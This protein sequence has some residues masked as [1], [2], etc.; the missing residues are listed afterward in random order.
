LWPFFSGETFSK[1]SQF[2]SLESFEISPGTSAVLKAGLLQTQTN[3]AVRTLR[4]HDN[5]DAVPIDSETIQLLVKRFPNVETLFL[6][7]NRSSDGAVKEI[8]G[9]LK[10]KKIALERIG[11][12]TAAALSRLPELTDVKLIANDEETV[13]QLSKSRSVTRLVLI[14][15][16][17]HQSIGYLCQMPRLNDLQ[18]SALYLLRGWGHP[19]APLPLEGFQ[20]CL[21]PLSRIGIKGP[22]G[23]FARN[24]NRKVLEALISIPTLDTFRDLAGEVLDL[25]KLLAAWRENEVD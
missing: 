21:A 12:E 15:P 1:F 23:S 17:T 10:L 3:S 19:K 6:R 9:F 14:A 16:F 18:F 7:T 11:P 13:M 8:G 25:E 22:T 20:K 24:L 2:P 5:G 4:I